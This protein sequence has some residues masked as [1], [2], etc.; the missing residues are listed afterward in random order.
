MNLIVY[1]CLSNYKL[2]ESNLTASID[3]DSGFVKDESNEKKDDAYSD[4]YGHVQHGFLPVPCDHK[5]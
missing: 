5:Q 3:L 4:S 2:T 1:V